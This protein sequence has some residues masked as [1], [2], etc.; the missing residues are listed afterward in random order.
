MSHTAP[1][2]E[3]NERN[4]QP[5]TE[6]RTLDLSLRNDGILN[7]RVRR[8]LAH[9]IADFLSVTPLGDRFTSFKRIL[10]V[11]WP[12]ELKAYRWN[13]WTERT[14]RELCNDQTAV[15]RRGN[16]VKTTVLSGCAAASKTWTSGMYAFLWWAV[17]PD[18]SIVIFT[19]TTREMVRRRIWPVVQHF[20]HTA[21]DSHG[22]EREWKLFNKVESRTTI[23][24]LGDSDEDAPSDKNAIFA[25]A[26]AH[27]ETQK[28]AHNLRGMH[29]ER[30]LLVVDEANGTPEAIFEAIP[31]QRKG[32]RDYQ[33]III[34][35]PISHLDCHGQCAIP[36]DGW[37]SIGEHVTEWKTKGVD[38]WQL[39][40]G[41]CL[42]FDGKNSP[43]VVAGE[44]LWPFIYTTADWKRASSENREK[45]LAYWSQ[46]RGLWPPDGFMQT[47]L[48][49]NMLAKY[50]PD[51][52]DPFSWISRRRVMA[53]LDPAFG[54]DECKL[55]FGELGDVEGGKDA[56]QVIKEMTI[57]FEGQRKDEIDYIIA[58]KCIDE[59][60][61]YGITPECFGLDR[62]GTGRGVA[63]I[64]SAE[65]SS[66]IHQVEF[67]SMATERPSS[68]AD[69]RPSR[70]VYYNRVTEMWWS[71]REFLE[72]G[73]LRGIPSQARVEL[74][75]RSYELTG[76]RYKLEPKSEFKARTG[77]S[78][79]DSD[80]L[81][82]LV[83]VARNLGITAKTG[84]SRSN[85]TLWNEFV[86]KRRSEAE[87]LDGNP[88]MKPEIELFE[89]GMDTEE[90]FT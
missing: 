71:L 20:F 15:I 45:T 25:M 33:A 10:G 66:S 2:S 75:T 38:K 42:K 41:I 50:D 81:A 54:G 68:T 67:G 21:K 46:D 49:E 76:R 4:R 55:Y 74:C 69:G 57:K 35:N 24:Y 44:D 16:R 32:C 11:I 72:A 7:M 6:V 8:T 70:E 61:R 14:C 77:Y 13:A 65:W 52:Q 3:C 17:A 60:K 89:H 30:I 43:N 51:G 29:A 86:E 9:E 12:E 78:P 27:G 26:V 59:C 56:I 34:G 19:S 22:H 73:Q 64:I 39:E 23:Q 62:T 5:E 84:S 90:M 82:G 37:G 79:D 63:A 28:A 80:A 40:P 58:R 85:N 36:E 48:T 53:F 47:I 18:K 88:A 1:E 87:E 83:D 31:N